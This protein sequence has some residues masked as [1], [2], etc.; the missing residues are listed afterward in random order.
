VQETNAGHNLLITGEDKL[1]EMLRVVQERGRYTVE[2]HSTWGEAG[3]A[4]GITRTLVFFFVL[5]D[6]C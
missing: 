2:F 1:A 5:G 3:A 4:H 6:H